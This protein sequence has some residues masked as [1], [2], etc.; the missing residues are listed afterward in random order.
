MTRLLQ[1]ERF[2]GQ[3]KQRYDQLR[4][5]FLSNTSLDHYIDSVTRFLQEAQVRHYERWDILGKDVGAPEVGQI[6]DTFEGEMTKF[7]NWIRTRLDWLDQHMPG[8]LETSLPDETPFLRVFPNPA[9]EWLYV[10]SSYLL[11]RVEICSL[12][13][14][15]LLVEDDLHGN[16]GSLQVSGL[17]S[18]LYLMHIF[19]MGGERTSHKLLIH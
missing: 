10:E 2:S 7:K 9:T 8:D 11:D 1:D 6:P 16:S 5:S 15:V 14:A 17:R 4:E 18:G 12:T 19:F 13:G 3:I